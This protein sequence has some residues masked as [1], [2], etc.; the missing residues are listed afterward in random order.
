MYVIIFVV[1]SIYPQDY[2]DTS[3][4][5]GRLQQKRLISSKRARTVVAASF[6]EFGPTCS[7]ETKS[8][9]SNISMKNK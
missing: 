4:G 7:V 2:C 1:L 3:G 6:L 8:S 9:P 5:L